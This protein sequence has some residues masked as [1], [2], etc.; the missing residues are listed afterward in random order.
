MNKSFHKCAYHHKLYEAS[1]VTCFSVTDGSG[2]ERI[3]FF[4]GD[5]G[6]PADETTD[7][8]GSAG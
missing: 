6:C 4:I 3:L 7:W 5:D 8:G 2:A 1:D